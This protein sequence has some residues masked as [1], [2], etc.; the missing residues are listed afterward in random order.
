M[1]RDSNLFTEPLTYQPDRWTRQQDNRSHDLSES[2]LAELE[3]S[4]ELYR[5]QQLVVNLVFG[6]G[7][8]MCLG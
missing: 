6:H 8:R 4:E 1:G 5:L 2:E 7:S 3:S